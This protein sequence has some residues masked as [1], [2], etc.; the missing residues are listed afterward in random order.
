MARRLL[1][2]AFAF[3]IIGGP[4]AARVCEAAC[5]EHA[6]HSI[7][8]TM[9]PSDDRYPAEVVSQPS[10]H[11]HSTVA[12]AAATHRARLRAVC[13]ACGHLEA[14]ISESRARMRAPVAPA[15]VTAAQGTPLLTR[16]LPPFQMDSRHGPPA[17]L[18]STS[19]LRI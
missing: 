8:S 11:H 13:H 14:F 9:P 2:F 16:V 19:P 6:G 10:H 7:D 15:V 5:T 18:R 17:P 4:L 3:V 1:A 12:P